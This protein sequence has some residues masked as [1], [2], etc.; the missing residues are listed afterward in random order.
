MTNALMAA[1]SAGMAVLLLLALGWG[2]GNL[3]A[4]LLVGAIQYGLMRDWNNPGR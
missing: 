3:A 2:W 4:A 1:T